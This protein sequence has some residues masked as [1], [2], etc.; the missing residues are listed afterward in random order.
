MT[1]PILWFIFS[2]LLAIIVLAFFRLTPKNHTNQVNNKQSSNADYY[3]ESLTL[4]R[5]NQKGQLVNQIN[6]Q[7]LDYFE[8][9]Q[10]SRLLK[11]EIQVIPDKKTGWRITAKR[12]L[13]EHKSETLDIN[14]SVIVVHDSINNLKNGLENVHPFKIKTKHLS[15]DLRKNIANTNKHNTYMIRDSQ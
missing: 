12:G 14:G 6:A 5:F 8:A 9:K 13:L 2:L 11:P 1:R 15:L 3:F 7:K 4:K 10:T